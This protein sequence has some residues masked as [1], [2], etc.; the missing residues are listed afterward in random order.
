MPAHCRSGAVKAAR[1]S[2]KRD[3]VAARDAA[4]RATDAAATFFGTTRAG[5][6]GERVRIVQLLKFFHGVPAYVAFMFTRFVD[7]SVLPDVTAPDERYDGIQSLWRGPPG[8]HKLEEA[9]L[10]VF[11]MALARA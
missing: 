9:R 6:T 4:K 10:A 11:D 1:A 2:T 7:G 5:S 8:Y 3:L